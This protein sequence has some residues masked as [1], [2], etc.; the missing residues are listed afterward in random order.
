[1]TAETPAPSAFAPGWKA[2]LNLEYEKRGTITVLAENSHVGPLRVQLPLYP[3]GEVCH[4][5][6]LHPPGGVVAGDRLEVEL[7]AGSKAHAL[8]TTPGATKFY[9]S[10]GATASQ[11]QRLTVSGG[12][13][14]WFPQDN[15]V[16][17]GAI[18]DLSTQV[19]LD[20]GARFIGWE[21]LCLG[22]PTRGEP[23]REGCLVSR[24]SVYRDGNPVFLERLDIAGHKD[25]SSPAGLRDRPVLATFIASGADRSQL[26]ELRDLQQSD[27]HGLLGFT[28]IDD[29]LIGRYLGDSTFEARELFQKAWSRLR[30]AL[31]GRPA[32]PPRIWST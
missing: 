10:A 11:H 3:E 17:P 6:I 29:L 27:R 21:V 15:I 2:R 19:H 32:C 31:L 18:A 12:I 24:F 16:F 25:L 8:I 28:L 22:L 23:F 14:E 13:L 30:P 9:R 5:C 26:D 7:Y 1:M 4:T 20:A